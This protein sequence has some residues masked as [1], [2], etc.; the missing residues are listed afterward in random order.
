MFAALPLF[1]QSTVCTLSSN[2]A[3]KLLGFKLG[4]TQAAAEK[5][6]GVSAEANIYHGGG[7]GGRRNK[8][9]VR[10]SYDIGE[11]YIFIENKNQDAKGLD[12]SVDKLNLLFFDGQLFKI[13]LTGNDK[14]EWIKAADVPAY[15]QKTYGIP[16]TAWTTDREQ[17]VG[18]EK[19]SAECNGV[20]FHYERFKDVSTT[21]SILNTDTKKLIEKALADAE[22]TKQ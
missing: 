4:M 9:V 10:K 18:T 14:T 17:I 11:K 7:G 15:F 13:A 12:A 20:S 3:P 19:Q 6:L 1:G 5:M 21:F 22:A 16:A 8:N 2:K